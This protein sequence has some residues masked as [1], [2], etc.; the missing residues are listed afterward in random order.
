M[1]TNITMGHKT[2]RWFEDVCPSQE[3]LEIEDLR[4][5]VKKLCSALI[6]IR[7]MLA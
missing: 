3:K 7:L 4:F 1:Y 2:M 6:K 5:D